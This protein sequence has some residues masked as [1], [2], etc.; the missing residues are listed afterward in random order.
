MSEQIPDI[1]FKSSILP[2]LLDEGTKLRF[3][4]YKGIS[5]FNACCKRADVTLAP[6]DIIR[7]KRRLGMS[8]TDFLAKHTVPFEMDADGL[9]GVKL[10]TDDQGAMVNQSRIVKTDIECSN[11]VIH[12]IDTVL[13]PKK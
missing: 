1:P 13:L 9:M 12:V 5:C 10:K 6:Y 2:K 3:R 7:L 8:S 4:C 11:G